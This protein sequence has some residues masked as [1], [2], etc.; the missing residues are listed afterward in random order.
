[1]PETECTHP[2][3]IHVVNVEQGGEKSTTYK[4]LSCGNLLT[5]AI[6]PFVITVKGRS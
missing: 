4:C 3:L 2:H 1:M 6:T 5:V